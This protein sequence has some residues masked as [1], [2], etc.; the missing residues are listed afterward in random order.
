MAAASST[1][2]LVSGEISR[3]PLRARDAVL[4]DTP[5]A[6]ATSFNVIAI[7]LLAGI[8]P[9]LSRDLP[10]WEFHAAMFPGN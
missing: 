8:D 4:R 1:A 2:A 9:I 5:A 10:R 3:E 7:L 6:P